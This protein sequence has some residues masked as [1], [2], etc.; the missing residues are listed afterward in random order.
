ME[1][2]LLTSLFVELET[3]SALF[4]FHFFFFWFVSFEAQKIFKFD[5]A[6]FIYVVVAEA[7]S[8]II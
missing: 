2:W 3:L 6:L 8:V 5:E 7:L 4:T 1:W